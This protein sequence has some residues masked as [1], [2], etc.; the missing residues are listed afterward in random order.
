MSGRLTS[1]DVADYDKFID[2]QASETVPEDD[3]PQVCLLLTLLFLLSDHEV[4]D[5][6]AQLSPRHR[7]A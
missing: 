7:R 2:T 6:T 3:Q 5:I 4:R 1:T